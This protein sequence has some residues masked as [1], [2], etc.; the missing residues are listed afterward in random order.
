MRAWQSVLDRMAVSLIG[1]WLRDSEV[2]ER[3]DRAGS[4]DEV[5]RVTTA[6]RAVGLAF[7]SG[8]DV[9]RARNTFGSNR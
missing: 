2:V 5:V 8:A 9:V 7:E 4:I 3:T 6:V 1:E